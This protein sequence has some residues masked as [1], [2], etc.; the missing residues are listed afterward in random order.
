MK[1]KVIIWEAEFVEIEEEPA[2]E[3]EIKAVD[4]SSFDDGIF[5][6]LDWQVDSVMRVIGG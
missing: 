4:S 2:Q 5:D 6:W 3:D 1:K